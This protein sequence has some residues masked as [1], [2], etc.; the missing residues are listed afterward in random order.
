VFQE[1]CS[2]LQVSLKQVYLVRRGYLNVRS[3]CSADGH[4]VDPIGLFRLSR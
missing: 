2:G 1:Q 3:L 4:D